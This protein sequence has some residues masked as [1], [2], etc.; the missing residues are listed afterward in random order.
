VTIGVP[1]STVRLRNPQ[2]A[3]V[4]VN[5]TESPV[6]WAVAAIPVEIKNAEGVAQIAP[7]TV[8]VH[9]RGP[10][11]ARGSGA[12]AF[13][14]TVDVEGLRPGQFQVPVRVIPPARI[15]VVRVEPADVRV[16]IK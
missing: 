11:D 2:S 5:V 12:D 13:E 9:V 14:A 1:D 4:T 8:T 3:K 16:R 10:R 7:S 15:G 6:E